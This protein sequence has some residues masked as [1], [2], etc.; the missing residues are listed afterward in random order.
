M[1]NYSSGNPYLDMLIG[2]L[3]KRESSMNYSAVG[4]ATKSGDRAYGYSQ[5]MGSNIGPWTQ[6]VLGQR[7]TPDQYLNSPEAQ[8]AVTSAKLRVLPKQIR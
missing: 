3:G 5:V 1:N 8:H 7:L 2:G 6:E 4:P